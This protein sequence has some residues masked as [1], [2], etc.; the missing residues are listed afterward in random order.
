MLPVTG[1]IHYSRYPAEQWEQ[2]ILKMKAGGLTIIPTYVF[3]NIHEEK[4]GVFDWN[5]NRDLR[6]FVELCKKHDM[7]VIVRIGPF[8]HG[9]IR[10]GGL[11][12]WLFAR[13]VEVR[14]NDVNY[15]KYVERL[16]NEIAVQLK[17]LYY[18]DGNLIFT[19]YEDPQGT[20]ERLY[21]KNGNL[22]R[23]RHCE[24]SGDP[25]YAVNHDN[26]D[27]VDFKVM[28]NNAKELS[29]KICQELQL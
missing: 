27:S 1:E 13:P 8:C 9:E 23:W 12:D 18:K 20:S 17:K 4:E 25:E 10:N 6:R 5:G 28:E 15:L 29:K 14:S 24:D 22:F 16:Y 21:F 3:W 19:Y 26:E 7:D 2:A 11:P